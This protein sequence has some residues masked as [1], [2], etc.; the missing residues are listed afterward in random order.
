MTV[1]SAAPS[2]P[3]PADW[4]GEFHG[5]ELHFIRCEMF[6]L[7]RIPDSMLKEEA[8]LMQTKWFDYRRLHPTKA[9]LLFIDAYNK[10]YKGF[11]RVAKDY[12]MAEGI[13]VY[14]G[15]PLDMLMSKEGKS[16]W[17]ARQ[18]FDRLG[19]RY[20]FALRFIMN[21]CLERGWTKGPRPAHLTN[22]DM[23]VML[24]LAW[25]EEQGRVIQRVCDPRYRVENFFG[26]SDQLAYE[27]LIVSQ[28]KL[29]RR[30]SAALHNALYLDCSIRFEEALRQFS[31][32]EIEEA[33][34]MAL[35]K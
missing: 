1:S 11:I 2:C 18:A 28:I 25:E 26:H 27:A 24:M 17:K 14:K 6:A 9:T 19:I 16:V 12:G 10:A 7:A 5:S 31:P 23:L 29:R 33:V 15:S 13:K 30:R 3:T 4:L 32:E 20:D 22:E 21:Y 35:C 34:S 8:E